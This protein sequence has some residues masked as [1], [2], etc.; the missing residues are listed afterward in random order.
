MIQLTTQTNH[1]GV[2]TG[3]HKEVEEEA[4]ISKKKVERLASRGTLTSEEDSDISS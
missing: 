2:S 4:T 1:Q 3:L